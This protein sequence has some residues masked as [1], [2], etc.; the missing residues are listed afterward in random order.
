MANRE[1]TFGF[2]GG[3]STSTENEAGVAVEPLL[4]AGLAVVAFAARLIPLARGAGLFGIVNYDDGVYFGAAL[5]FADGRI[6]YRDFLLLH[7]P[8]VVVLYGPIAAL[9]R[10]AGDAN[11]LAIA[12]VATIALG[13]ANTVLV[14]LVASRAGRAAA[15]AAGAFYAVWSS[16]VVVEQ[17][18]W[19]IAPQNTCVL[20]A[21]LALGGATAVGRVSA[22]RA[23]VIG[24][25][26]AVDVTLQIWNI[27]PAAVVGVL[28]VAVVARH[29]S[30]GWRAPLVGS[31][32]GA[33]V[34][35]AVVV[36]PFAV[37][38]GPQM[39][40]DVILDQV[41]RGAVHAS[42]LYRVETVEGMPGSVRSP[43]RTL[44]N[45]AA[46]GG[47]LVVALVVAFAA[48]R[49]PVVRPWLALLVAQ[50]AVLLVLPVYFPHYR[51]WLAPAATLTI[52]ASV[53]L[54][55]DALS[56]ARL[57]TAF[58]GAV[59]LVLAVLL[60]GTLAQRF[61]AAVPLGRLRAAVS[62]ARCVAAD[63][64]VVLI[65]ADVFTSS[66]RS[67]CEVKIDV[68][69][70]SY[71][72]AARNSLPATA[73]ATLAPYQRSMEAYYTSADVVAFTRLSSGDGLAPATLAALRAR[74]PDRTV[75]GPVILMT[76]R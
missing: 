38:A 14:A 51:A 32:V 60:G 9:S 53:A 66:L 70:E 33:A 4:L 7:P 48:W 11:A 3:R 27:V 6:P 20:V 72:L 59:V 22:A 52:G 35:L 46:I 44:A 50:G 49:R 73:R 30:S 58:R 64:P 54:L 61:G 18:T 39:F 36:L 5:A 45:V 71:D 31:V 1:V 63:S 74:F 21:L 12:R 57:R 41:G 76:G 43:F 67:G 62:S 47:A 28:L 37:L 68:S 34:A 10:I 23:G 24:A 65:E 15:L 26:M 55:A 40:R 16:A 56:S 13:A 17:A 19:L 42:L 25:A 29:R 69:G 75:L 8:G 2:A